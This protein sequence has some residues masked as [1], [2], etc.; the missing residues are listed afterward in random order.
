VRDTIPGVLLLAAGGA[1]LAS[2]SLHGLVNIPHLHEDLLEIGVRHTLIVAIMLV[3]YFSVVA[4]FAFAGLVLAGALDSLRGKPTH[5][6]ALWIV[7]GSYLVFGAAAFVVVGHSA[8]LLGYAF[9]GA[10]VAVGIA[11]GRGRLTSRAA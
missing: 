1:M 8:H 5:E 9:M 7:A 4:M 2:A 6:T 3:L 10:L 11:L